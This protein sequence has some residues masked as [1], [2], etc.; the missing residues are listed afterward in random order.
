MA[1][2]N[3]DEQ[4]NLDPN[5]NQYQQQQQE[6]PA[7]PRPS[8]GFDLDGWYQQMFGRAP[9]QNERETDSVNIDKYGPSYFMSDFQKRLG[10]GGQQQAP[11]YSTPTQQW[12]AQPAAQGQSDEL[13]KLLM[14]RATQGTAV[15]RNDP[16]IRQ[17]VDPVVAQQERA[18]RNYLDDVAERSGPLANMQGER[19]LVAERQ[20]QAA[21][22]FESEVIGRE[23]AAKRDEIQQALSLYGSMLS[24]DKRIALQQQL[25]QL[26]AALR[27]E[28]YGLQREG[29]AQGNDQFMREL[30]LREWMAGDSSDRAWAGFGG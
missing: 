2:W 8:S 12:N 5:T 21:G 23:I 26:D 1:L 30:A 28:G 7:A 16:N 3:P 10:N 6:A 27:R 9:D 25:S 17:Q 29:M 20:G 14:Q 19:R 11:Q 18:G 13:Y 24:D 15:N 22:A 4:Y